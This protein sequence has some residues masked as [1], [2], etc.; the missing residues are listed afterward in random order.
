VRSLFTPRAQL[1]ELGDIS[2]L[3]IILL[4]GGNSICISGTIPSDTYG[5]T[6]KLSQLEREASP[7]QQ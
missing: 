7:E 1:R 6:G 5:Y 3:K 2:E 4:L